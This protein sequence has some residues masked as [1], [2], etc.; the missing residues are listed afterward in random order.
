MPEVGSRL[1]RESEVAF[2]RVTPGIFYNWSSVEDR[3]DDGVFGN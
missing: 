3:L 2:F 1:S